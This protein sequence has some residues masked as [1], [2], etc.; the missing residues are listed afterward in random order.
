VRWMQSSDGRQPWA[1]QP[2]DSGSSSCWPMSGLG[3]LAFPTLPE[4][5]SPSRPETGQRTAQEYESSLGKELWAPA[6]VSKAGPVAATE[7]TAFFNF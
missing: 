7:T 6:G 1:P 4:T 2:W 5:P 3:G